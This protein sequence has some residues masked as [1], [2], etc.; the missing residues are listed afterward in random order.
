MRLCDTLSFEALMIREKK[1]TGCCI[2]SYIHYLF[3]YFHLDTWL[4]LVP[5]TLTCA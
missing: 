1:R 5:Q 3:S 4:Y 2:K